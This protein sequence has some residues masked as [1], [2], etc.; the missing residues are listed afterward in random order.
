MENEKELNFYQVQIT[1][2]SADGLT[3][4]E[5]ELTVNFPMV[6]VWLDD[7]DE[8]PYPVFPYQITRDI[9]EGSSEHSKASARIYRLT[10]KD[11]FKATYEEVPHEQPYL[12]DLLLNDSE[13]LMKLDQI[14]NALKTK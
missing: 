13:I 1:W 10:H 6:P 11:G 7:E 14:L 9:K 5:E 4:I 12:R 3:S 2:I 8:N